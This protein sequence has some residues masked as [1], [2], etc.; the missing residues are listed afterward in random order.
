MNSVADNKIAKIVIISILVLLIGFMIISFPSS[1]AKQ[2]DDYI[3]S[4][5]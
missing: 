5:R 4:I 1:S 2:T 3:V